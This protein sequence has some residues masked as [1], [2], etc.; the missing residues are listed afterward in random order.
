MLQFTVQGTSIMF[1]QVIYL[2]YFTDVC[3]IINCIELT[4]FIDFYLYY[5]LLLSSLELWNVM[6]VLPGIPVNG[7]LYIYI[8]LKDYGTMHSGVNL[9]SLNDICLSPVL[10]LFHIHT[11]HNPSLIPN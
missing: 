4:I 2:I 8:V 11:N 10:S 3:N 5:L 7:I 6:Q 9:L 1:C